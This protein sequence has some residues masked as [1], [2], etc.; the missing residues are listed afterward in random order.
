MFLK[1]KSY[2][3]IVRRPLR[4][5]RIFEYW[6]LLGLDA[7]SIVA[8]W[9]WAFA[10]GSSLQLPPATLAILALGTWLV[11][12]SD[13]LL[14]VLLEQEDIRKRHIFHK[15]HWRMF[16]VA[17]VLVLGTIVYLALFQMPYQAMREDAALFA[18][19]IVYFIGVHLRGKLH[20]PKEM[21]VGLIFALATAVPTWSRL[22]PSNTGSLIPVL[23]F[24][25]VAWL[26]CWA[27]EVWEST[28]IDRR[29]LSAIVSKYSLWLAI[30]LTTVALY[31]G[32]QL[33]GI[34]AI[35]AFLLFVID[36]RRGHW[37]TMTLRVAADA[38]MLTPLL[39]ML[40]DYLSSR[41]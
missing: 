1:T 19:A 5:P 16:L 15:N 18:I 27:I 17:A 22:D 3:E 13:R 6:H 7:P 31:T 9:A 36:R 25:L 12:V 34:A 26:N 28:T 29:R 14:D 21:I 32:E 20:L 39:L 33:A 35:S 2:N 24:A 40:V 10:R 8:L 41:Q 23:A 37:A 38:A 30:P 4:L 11:Y